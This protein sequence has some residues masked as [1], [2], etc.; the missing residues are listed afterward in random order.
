MAERY[1][2]IRHRFACAVIFLLLVSCNRV[3]AAEMK[4]GVAKVEITPPLG[5]QMW[6]YFDRL[7]GAEGI[8][9]PLYARVL[10]LETGGK[11][12]AYVDLDLGRTFG[13][14]PL[15]RL[16]QSAKR[17]SGIDY[18][19]VQATHTHAGPV[20][21]DEYPSETPAWE[22]AALGKI[23]KA[24]HDAQQHTVP[25]RMGTGYGQAYIG[26]NRRRIDSDGAVTMIWDNPSRVP[27]WPVDPTITVLRIDQ[28][29]G[30]PLAILVNYAAHPV[31]F[32]GD[33]LRY[34]A[35]FPGVMCK[36]VE[37]NFDG[38]PL[39]FFVQGAPGDIN[40]YDATTP[41]TQDAIGR[42]DWAGETLG[43]A[44]ADA[45]KAIQTRA[46][47]DSSL[48]FAEDSLPFNLRW[49]PEKFRQAILRGISPL[50]FQLYSPPIQETMHLP[51][52]TV[53]IDRKIAMMGMPGEP[54]LEFQTNWRA[55]CPVEKCLFLG[56]TN[57]YYGYFPTIRAATEGGYGAT[58]ATSWVQTGAGEQMEDHALVE[59]YR[60]M[61]RLQDAPR[62]DWKDSR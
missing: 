28:M 7:K 57:G 56:Y 59:L 22:P 24:I 62:T 17:S 3:N 37:Q 18:L 14:A 4:A 43:K 29:D 36:V 54:F 11:R 30:Q 20:I 60:M 42:R 61:G 25:V 15:D 35:D 31:T 8:L 52:I 32:G 50:A 33:N 49:D 58:S 26:Y 41:I 48:D 39:A 44:A 9:D 10:V 23:D 1:S 6:G 34:S 45:A 16:K 27:T 51:V 38:K 19:I 12:L 53:L 2:L 21:M 46:D 47:P 5:V 13:P 55:R 40:V